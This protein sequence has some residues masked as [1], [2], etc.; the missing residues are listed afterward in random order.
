MNM[1]TFKKAALLGL[2][3][4]L[5]ISFGFSQNPLVHFQSAG[6]RKAFY[7]EPDALLI[8]TR[9][10]NEFQL[11]RLNTQNSTFESLQDSMVGYITEA[12]P[13]RNDTGLA[14]ANTTAYYTTDGWAS[15]QAFPAGTFSGNFAATRINM[16]RT[17]NGYFTTTTSG[18]AYYSNN[19]IQWQ[20]VSLTGMTG[21][22]SLQQLAHR[23]GLTYFFNNASNFA[24]STDGG[25]NFRV[26]SNTLSSNINRLYPLDDANL[27][28]FRTT[29]ISANSWHYSVDTGKTFTSFQPSLPIWY[30]E[31][32]DSLFALRRD[33]LFLSVD[34]GATFTA[35]TGPLGIRDLI[36]QVPISNAS[37]WLFA[38][39]NFAN[40]IS[41]PWQIGLQYAGQNRAVHFQGSTGILAGTSTGFSI[42][43]N[44][45]GT[46]DFKLPSPAIPINNEIESV[47]AQND[48]T[49]FAA[50]SDG[51]IFKS[52]DGGNS[53]QRKLNITGTVIQARRFYSVHPD[54]LIYSCYDTRARIS[55]NGGESWRLANNFFGIFTYSMAPD[56]SVY[57]ASQ[58][59]QDSNKLK[60]YQFTAANDLSVP[61]RTITINQ[62]LYSV[63]ALEMYDAQL[64]YLLVQDMQ[65]QIHLFRT[66]DAWN[67]H[68]YLGPTHNLTTDPLLRS[69]RYKIHLPSADTIYLQR[70]SLV[71]E[72][73]NLNEVYA[74]YDRGAQWQTVPVIPTPFQHSDKL[75]DLHFFTPQTFI[76]VWSSSRILLNFGTGSGGGSS[77][78]QQI[79]L[80]LAFR[81]Y[82]NPAVHSISLSLEEAPERVEIYSITGKLCATPHSSDQ[83]PTNLSLFRQ[84]LGKD[85]EVFFD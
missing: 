63:L 53:W 7:L 27:L 76:S 51:D 72:D 66:N 6:E 68:Q 80:N 78:L 20:S 38:G 31:R 50:D 81:P 61:V 33:T 3:L 37:P 35:Q 10:N 48:S 69:I 2:F 64:G 36:T 75:V 60:I 26:Y 57:A 22:P 41:G 18:N 23:E 25:Q 32:L 46:F 44:G 30:A 56:G 52:T 13:L 47:F 29:A 73:Y 77:S 34:T 16:V 19:G 45:G 17:Q 43:Q 54:T 8:S 5:N 67:S 21:P 58:S 59:S 1:Q 14:I 84:H 62:T 55:T 49:F 28:A 40:Q 71:D 82:P 15:Y 83:W 79:D 11:G 85:V 12:L 39:S 74:S 65:R 42:T 24:V 4:L 9:T 70:L